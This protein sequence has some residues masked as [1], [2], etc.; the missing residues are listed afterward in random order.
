MT[1]ALCP[2]GHH[3]ADPEWCDTCGA[4]IGA[5]PAGN[6]SA[7][8]APVSAAAPDQQAPVGSPNAGVQVDC[9]N[10][11]LSNDA[12]N[13]TRLQRF[14][15]QNGTVKALLKKAEKAAKG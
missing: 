14:D 15:N 6:P 4:P 2:N 11:G 5:S 12:A 3:S 7:A 8:S 1:T 13:K 10:C 9:P